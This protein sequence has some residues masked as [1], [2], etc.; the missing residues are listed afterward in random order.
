MDWLKQLLTRRRR[1]DELS[2][3]IR[4]HLD[5]KIADLMDRGMTQEQAEQAARREF[6]NVARIE[7]RSR[8]VWEWPALRSIWA[9]LKYAIRQL[10]KS[11]AFATTS[12][13]ILALGIGANTGIFTLTHTLLLKSLPIPDPDNLVRIA[14]DDPS[15]PTVNGMPLNLFLM[16]SLQRH[17]KSFSGIFGWFSSDVVLTQDGTS[18]IYPGA[19]LSGNAFQVLEVRPAAGRL[20]ILADDQTGGGPDG[21]AVVIS[22]RF[23]MQHYH[24]DPSIV[25]KQIVLSRHDA[26][27]VGIAPTGFNGVI[28]GTSP[29]F[30]MPLAFEPLVHGKESLLRSTG[31]VWLTAWARLK[32]DVSQTSASAEMGPLF[33]VVMNETAPAMRNIL[34]EHKSRFVVLPGRTGWSY[35]RNQYSKP[36]LLL[37]ALVGVVLLVCCINLAGLFLTRI[38]RREHEFAIRSSLGATRI[39]LMRQLLVEALTIS[40]AGAAL[41]IAFSWMTDRYLLQFMT[42]KG[43]ERALSVRPDLTTLAVTAG[44]AI[45]CALLFGFIPAWLAGHASIEPA[46][47]RSSH[48]V[49]TGK[50]TLVRRIFLPMQIA[51]SLALVVVATMLGTSVMH[52]RNSDPGFHTENVVLATEDF[53]GVPQKGIALV[54]L[55]QEMVRNIDQMPGVIHASVAENTPLNGWSHTQAF[56]KDASFSSAGYLSEKYEVNDVGTGYFASL[57]TQLLAGRDFTDQDTETCIL[58]REAARLLFPHTTAIG[59]SLYENVGNTVS[60]VDAKECRVIGTVQD[61]KY[62][63]LRKAAPPTV[64]LPFGVDTRRLQ[65]MTFIIHAHTLAEGESAYRKALH[66]FSPSSPE[67]EPIAFAVQFNDAI[68]SVRLLSTL[69]ELFGVLVLLLSGIG[70]YGLTASY[71]N[72]R[73]SEIGVRMAFGATRLAIFNLIMKQ[74]SILLVIGMVAGTCLAI[75]A[76]HSI[77]AFLYEVNPTSLAF[78]AGAV[79]IL[80]LCGFMAALLPTHK[81]ISI[82]PMQALR[83]E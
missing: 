22:H 35:W 36:L 6:G 53:E 55:Y 3:S 29:D 51:L 28:V 56:S 38:A 68:S 21:W 77:K 49:L 40:L 4:E 59:Q 52:L 75:V 79:V 39:R 10:L 78:F 26:T 47:R 46:L 67:T 14:I 63:S 58:N 64:F 48:N 2:E 15:A 62:V 42:N 37:Q 30:Y 34:M 70:V 81:A 17:A 74:V 25:G 24:G 72:Q 66:E 1:Y 69:S 23:W 50:G 61:A 11:P 31:S 41:A 33:H 20:L 43:T 5:E 9:D 83:T 73:T 12:V 76:A 57:G 18:R 16:Q 45:L 71:V 54:H 32:P 8:E 7:E 44:C 82:D 13:L 80:A 60:G 65:G 19:L 27:I